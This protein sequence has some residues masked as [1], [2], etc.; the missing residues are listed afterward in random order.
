MKNELSTLQHSRKYNYAEVGS[1]RTSKDRSSRLTEQLAAA[2]VPMAE[3]AEA[4]TV[5]ISATYLSSAVHTLT[6]SLKDPEHLRISIHDLIEAYNQL[7]RKIRTVA[8][9]ISSGNDTPSFIKVFREYS[10]PLTECVARDICQMVPDPFESHHSFDIFPGYP[11]SLDEDN[12][13]N[14]IDSNTL[15]QYALRF[16]SD[17]F[18]FPAI[19]SNFSDDH[20]T[21]ILNLVL[22]L[23]TGKGP[24][25][26]YNGDKLSDMTFWILKVQRLPL[27][28]VAD[29]KLKI[30]SALKTSFSFDSESDNCCVDAFKAVH[31]ILERF[32]CACT[33]LLELLPT[34]L[35]R[36]NEGP[37]EFRIHAAFALAGFAS[38]KVALEFGHQFP[39]QEAIQMVKDFLDTEATMPRTANTSDSRFITSLISAMQNTTRKAEPN[40]SFVLTVVPCFVVLLEDT[41]LSFSRAIRAIVRSIE[42]CERHVVPAVCAL[43]ADLWTLLIWSYSLLPT[44]AAKQVRKS[45]GSL[46]D[47]AFEVLK[48]ALSHRSRLAFVYTLLGSGRDQAEEIRSGQDVRR[49]ID[50][51]G[52]M[53]KKDDKSAHEG[54][55]ILCRLLSTIGA[56]PRKKK[57]QIQPRLLFARELVNGSFLFQPAAEIKVPE[58]KVS[59]EELSPLTESEVLQEWKGLS[60]AW[61]D[62]VQQFLRC[63]VGLPSEVLEV[64]QA[65]LLAHAELQA[66]DEHL[67]A[68]PSFASE[69]VSILT[70]FVVPIDTVDKQRLYLSSMR[71]LWTVLKNVFTSKFWLATP[72]EKILASLLMKHFTLTDDTVKGL[73]SQLCGDLIALGVP[74]LLQTLHC[75]GAD[76]EGTEVKRRLWNLVAENRPVNSSTT[77]ED[78][79]KTLTIPFGAWDLSSAEIESWKRLFRTAIDLAF[80]S[81][82]TTQDVLSLFMAELGDP[83]LL[84][85]ESATGVLQQLLEELASQPCTDY[86]IAILSVINTRL[87]SCH[88]TQ[89]DKDRKWA[90]DT[91]LLIGQ[92]IKNTPEAMIVRVLSTVQK[93]LHCWLADKELL[94]KEEHEELLTLVYEVQNIYNPSLDLL[95]GMEPTLETLQ[96]LPLFLN[97]VF[98][99]PASE[100][101]R[102]FMNFWGDTYHQRQDI[103]PQDY[104]DGIKTA[105]KALADVLD[106]SFGDGFHLCSD[107]SASLESYTISDSQPSVDGQ[108][109]D[110]FPPDFDLSAPLPKGSP[111]EVEVHDYSRASGS[112]RTNVPAEYDSFVASQEEEEE[113][114]QPEVP[115]PA[116]VKRPAETELPRTPK[117]RRKGSRKSSERRAGKKWASPSLSPPP[118][119]KRHRAASPTSSERFFGVGSPAHRSNEG[120]S[121]PPNDDEDDYDTW[122][123]GV[124][125]EDVRELRQE[126]HSDFFAADGEAMYEDE[127]P[128]G[129]TDPMSDVDEAY[130]LS[131]SVGDFPPRS[132]GKALSRTTSLAAISQPKATPLRKTKTMST[133]EG[134]K[135]KSA[136]LRLLEQAYDIIDKEGSSRMDVRE[137]VETR[138]MMDRIK[139]V[140]EQK[141]RA[142]TP[143]A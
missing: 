27:D 48:Q 125:V 94:S 98:N 85:P 61:V 104:P 19:Y 4:P 12:A 72:A 40:P 130:V 18:S 82:H 120:E 21:T 55:K 88:S 131:P 16:V 68:S 81:S 138:A 91:L 103:S 46:R 77:W 62:A 84:I 15:C 76:R 141:M 42:K 63:D 43:H 60:T 87:V 96:A 95:A 117:R 54:V 74:S 143:C 35:Q 44:D 139:L 57:T 116:A 89:D 34:I 100:G 71:K 66:G 105:V 121:Q 102:S 90:L 7:S 92:L 8:S 64:W 140:I 128:S 30:I 45:G 67:S 73:W 38:A 49:A 97:S 134:E 142:R 101:I 65:L 39:R 115:A 79:V 118:P 32:P 31:Q 107:D 26:V 20:L 59:I 33:W 111:V 1:A 127:D 52:E 9:T 132:I 13:E 129:D 41:A 10:A 135:S 24:T 137:L 14:A 126:E 22:S 122:E 69:V 6:E 136:H 28:I 58:V 108:D 119:A 93:G 3:T 56:S 29:Q 25:A 124:S 114:S 112:R 86:H 99:R 113:A 51:V 53:V 2:A 110:F 70:N 78:I 109:D 36:L 50:L 133:L 47:I 23:C 5:Q 37:L 17:M 106:N 80:S 11:Q 83:N 123:L 75:G